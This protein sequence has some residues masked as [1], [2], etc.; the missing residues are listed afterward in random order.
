[1][2]SVTPQCL[3]NIK[4]TITRPLEMLAWGDRRGPHSGLAPMGLRLS[5]P[6]MAGEG[7]RRWPVG[8]APRW[9]RAWRPT[10]ASQADVLSFA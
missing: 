7:D 10:P 3:P 4:Q 2:S 6:R 5:V 9:G 8:D 1:M